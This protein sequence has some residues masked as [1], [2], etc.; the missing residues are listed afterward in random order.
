MNWFSLIFSFF[1]IYK[2]KYNLMYFVNFARIKFLNVINKESMWSINLLLISFHRKYA[3]AYIEKLRSI[4]K[5]PLN[6]FKAYKPNPNQ[7]YRA[8]FFEA[9]LLTLANASVS[10][11]W[12]GWTIAS[13]RAGHTSTRIRVDLTIIS[14]ESRWAC[15]KHLAIWSLQTRA[16]IAAFIDSA[17]CLYYLDLA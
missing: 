1:S 8:S 15:A 5:S 9:A 3:C 10:T 14:S 12:S 13:I 16:I 17:W 6:I 4:N 7:V 2:V 11:V